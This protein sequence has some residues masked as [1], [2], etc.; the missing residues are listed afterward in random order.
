MA[1][2]V[3]YAIIPF[4]KIDWHFERTWGSYGNFASLECIHMVHKSAA[5]FLFASVQGASSMQFEKFHH[6]EY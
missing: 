2:Y 4:I 5:I 1:S 3:C 6:K